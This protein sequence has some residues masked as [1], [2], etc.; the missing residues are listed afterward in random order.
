MAVVKHRFDTNSK[1]N[2]MSFMFLNLYQRE[3]GGK[4]DFLVELLFGDKRGRLEK[5]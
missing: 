3:M 1:N 2:K 5:K 4:Y